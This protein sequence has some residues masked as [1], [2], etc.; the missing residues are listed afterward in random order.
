M[1]D[2]PDILIVGGHGE[3]GRRFAAQLESAHPGRV[4]VAGRNPERAA[5]LRSR[6]I[7]VDAPDSIASALVGVATL[8]ACVRERTRCRFAMRSSIRGRSAPAPRLRASCGTRRG[9]GAWS[10]SWR[11]SG[12]EHGRRI[13]DGGARSTISPSSSASATRTATSSRSSLK[14]RGAGG[15]LR[16]SLSGVGQ[17]HA[18]AVGASATVEALHTGEVAQPGVWLAEQVLDPGAFLRRLAAEGLVPVMDQ[19]TVAG[20]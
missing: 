3:V 10:Q 5:G 6:R 19:T 17:A 7:D 2:N 4:V 13:Q 15:V 9:L 20:R 1:T 8:V 11:S 18:T 12:R 14:V 16:A